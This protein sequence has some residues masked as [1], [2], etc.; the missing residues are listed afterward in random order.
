MM[1]A[2]AAGKILALAGL[3][4]EHGTIDP[5]VSSSDGYAEETALDIQYISGIAPGAT[6]EVWHAGFFSAQSSDQSFSVCAGTVGSSTH[7]KRC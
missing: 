1:R 6:T 5:G 7:T 3:T 2:T 4:Y